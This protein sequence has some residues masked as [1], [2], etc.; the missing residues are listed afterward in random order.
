MATSVA[1]RVVNQWLDENGRVLQTQVPGM[2]AVFYD[3]DQSG[4]LTQVSEG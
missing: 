1:G 3:Y 4:Q 2:E